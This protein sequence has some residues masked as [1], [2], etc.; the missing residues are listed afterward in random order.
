MV[1]AILEGRK[2]VTRRIVEP[3][4]PAGHLLVGRTISSTWV[5][6]EG[7][8]VWSGGDNAVALIEPHRVRCPYG[9]PGD[10]L[11]VK[12]RW[13]PSVTHSH[14]AGECDCGDVNVE[15]RADGEV[16][17]FRDGNIPFEWT[18]PKAAAR[19]DVTPLFMPRWASRITLEVT[20]VRVERLQ[21]IHREDA[22]AEG[23]ADLSPADH[24]DFGIPGIAVAQHPVRAFQ[25]LWE[26]INGVGSWDANP[27]VWAVEFKRLTQERAHA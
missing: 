21:D 7:K 4:P 20:G 1:R 22:L 5:A 18:M 26:S 11:W 2:T 27:W 15:Y 14:G 10:R 3:Q 13:R 12:E 17:F 16:R 19:G 23:I 25:L 9:Q 6:D 8:W 24:I